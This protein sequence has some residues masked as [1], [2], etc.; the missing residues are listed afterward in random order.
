MKIL[1]ALAAAALIPGQALAR[2]FCYHYPVLASRE[3]RPGKFLRFESPACEDI[4]ALRFKNYSGIGESPT[5]KELVSIRKALSLKES[6]FFTMGS[7]EENCRKAARGLRQW[8]NLR[9]EEIRKF[10]NDKGSDLPTGSIII[11]F[12]ELLSGHEYYVYD[13][14]CGSYKEAYTS[15]TERKDFEARKKLKK[16]IN[17]GDM[18]D[19]L[20]KLET[21][22]KRGD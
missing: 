19:D 13:G 22:A 5:E 7:S 6:W 14:S 9:S 11:S 18:I 21:Y 16:K 17:L 20:I 2:E 12:E 10:N 8:L 3:A 1:L 15:L 4:T